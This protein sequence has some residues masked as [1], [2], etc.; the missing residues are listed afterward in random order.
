M[1]LGRGGRLW[2]RLQKLRARRWHRI[3][4]AEWQRAGRPLPPPH[5]FKQALL[6]EY[7]GKH[8][9]A[10]LVET[11]THTGEMVEA[12]RDEFDEVYSVE[13]STDL[14]EKA[15]QRFAGIANVHLIQG[16]SGARLGEIIHRLS[17]PA[18]F[19]LDG[20]Y[21]AGATARGDK[22]TPVLAEIAEILRHRPLGH[23]ILVDDARL[24][25]T[26][27][28]YPTVDHLEQIVRADVPNA[29]LSVEDDVIRIVLSH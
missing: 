8:G 12:M 24:F 6:R 15:L 4:I 19:W 7:S 3:E 10:I 11:G 13:L 18:L 17:R 25:G 29:G 27:P 5:S 23:V 9:L 2:R 14:H 16:D 28:S 20:H 22:D 21:S 1:T 26:D